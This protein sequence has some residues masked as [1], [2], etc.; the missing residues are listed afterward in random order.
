MSGDIDEAIAALHAMADLNPL[1]RDPLRRS[2]DC[3]GP[4]TGVPV[5]VKAN[6]AIDGLPQCGASPALDDH[7]AHRSA[8]T[9]VRLLEAG[10]VIVGQANLHELAFGITSHNVHHGPV[11]NPAN[12][13]HMAGGSSG[14][15][16][17]AVAGGAVPMGLAS[18]TGGSGRLPAAM[19]GCVGFRP[20]HG[21]YPGDGVLTLSTSFDT[22]TPMARDVA[23]IAQLDAVLAAEAPVPLAEMQNLRL[24][25]VEDALWSGVDEPMARACRARLDALADHGVTLVP[26]SA[27]ELLGQCDEIA[28]GIVLYETRKFWTQLLAQ[29]DQ[30][31]ADF[32][33]QIA[34]PDVAGVFQMIVDGGAPSDDDYAQMVGPKR[35]AIRGRVAGLL[36]GLDGLVMPTLATT[37]PKIGETD[38]CVINGETVELFTAMT[39]RALVASITGNPSIS[40]PA[41]QLN[42]LPIGLE[43][44]GRHGGDL[45]LLAVAA[46]L[47]D[48]LGTG[49]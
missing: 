38:T 21:R 27:P 40:V 34:S 2:A 1:V 37:A 6:I 43:V 49:P 26:L 41:G 3:D 14:G 5:V 12:P 31:L 48:L 8:P 42:G 10:A 36:E 46:R 17:A 25:V 44:I 16:A 30:T 33:A 28:L 23:G 22:V 39:R 15:T 9:V 29:R 4:L 7:I 20:T 24:G 18:D 45:D 47:E 19:C 32:P 13:A 35:D 11:G